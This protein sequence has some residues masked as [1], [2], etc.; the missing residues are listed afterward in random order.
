MRALRP[1]IGQSARVFRA[2]CN[3]DINFSLAVKYFPQAKFYIATPWQPVQTLKKV[4]LFHAKQPCLRF[5][6]KLS[7]STW[8]LFCL[9]RLNGLGNLFMLPVLY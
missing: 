1:A 4:A 8:P 9:E 7:I 2:H 6:P 5:V 3:A